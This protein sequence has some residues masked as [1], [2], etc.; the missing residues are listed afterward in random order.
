MGII[1]GISGLTD[2]DSS[3]ALLKDGIVLAAAAEERFTRVKHDSRFPQNAIAFCLNRAGIGINN[4]SDITIGFDASLK[5]AFPVSACL[6]LLKHIYY[7]E[8]IKEHFWYYSWW[9][10]ASNK[11]IQCTRDLFG[12]DMTI[13]P[14]E[15]HQCHAATAFLLSGFGKAAIITIDGTGERATMTMG[16]GKG[17]KIERIIQI[18]RP[19]SL[20]LLYSEVTRYLGFK[21]FDEYKVMGLAAYGT[22]VLVEAFKNIVRIEKRGRFC[23]NKKYFI[24]YADNLVG[25]TDRFFR[26]F[27]MPRKPGEVISQQHKDIAF[28]L[29]KTLEDVICHSANYICDQTGETDLCISGGVSLNGMAVGSVLK[30]TKFKRIF[31]DPSPDD[32]GTALG[33]A[34]YRHHLNNG[35]QRSNTIPANYWGPEFSEEDICHAIDR[36]KII[37]KRCADPAS[38]AAKLVAGG[39]V[40]GWFQGRMEWGQRA[41]GNRSILA[42]PRRKDMRE[43][44]N[45]CV[46][47]R[48]DFR[49]F[50]PS[51]TH[52]DAFRYFDM[53]QADIPYMNIVVPALQKTIELL[54]SVVH[55]DGTAR[56]HTV[57]KDDNPLFWKFLRKME[58]ITGFPI[59]LNTSFN[60]SNEPIVCT[61]E[62]AIRC[63]FGS[64]MDS[65]FLGN[66]LV[67]K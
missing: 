20:G 65:L 22:P 51:V 60:V 39:A 6:K 66:Y 28:A 24:Y 23:L 45:R 18:D 9:R 12:K 35:T 3:A 41:L 15:H 58:K 31:V 46:K 48:E 8:K 19:D 14:V 36:C 67:V 52:E 13:T 11:A 7:P 33:S 56:V 32:S 59:L 37:S 2:H 47:N 54:P 40:V 53:L 42:D 1:L 50:A 61:P 25:L 49:P 17:S 29:Q 4:V 34:L 16:C 64:G 57:R 5:V 43:I 44:V 38:E 27:G 26:E 30:R 63:F 10:G 62:D 21:Y 55:V